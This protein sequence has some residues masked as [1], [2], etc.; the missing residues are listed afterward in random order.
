[1]AARSA[2]SR[3]GLG[4]ILVTRGLLSADQLRLSFEQQSVSGQR[5]GEIVVEQG[6]V[7]P[8]DLALALSEQHNLP[9]LDILDEAID[10]E[11]A[12]LL[13]EHL[14]QRYRALPVRV[15]DERT[16]LVAVSDPAD[17]QS[18][19]GLRLALKRKIELAVADERDLGVAQRRT[20]RSGGDLGEAQDAVSKGKDDREDIVVGA[21]GGV[22]A[23]KHVHSALEHCIAEGASDI[24]FE[25]EADRVVVRARVDGMMR[26][27]ATIPK[28]L[29]SE[30]TTRLKIMASLDI[31]E[32]RAPQDGRMFVKV[33]MDPVDLRVAV[34]PTTHG[35]QVVVRVLQRTARA[36][37]L[38]E[39]GMHPVAQAALVQA[40][41]QPH[42]AI[43]ACG[44]T[45]SGKTTTLYSALELL[46]DPTRALMTIEDPVEYAVP[47]VAQI[48][49]RPRSGLTFAQ[50]LRTLL[51][52]DPDVL[53]IGEIR[54]D[55]T[56]R[57]A[58][59]AAMTGHLVLTSLHTHGATSAIERL[60][61]MGVEPSLLSA[62]L[63][64]IV[65]Q[66]LAR[67]L[68]LECRQPYTPSA[69]DMEELEMEGELVPTL[70]EAT[71][72]ARCGR[73]GYRGRV[74][75]YE[76]LPVRERVRSLVRATT[77]EIAA[78]AK[79]EG[80]RTLKQEGHRLAVEGVTSLSEVRRVTG[81]QLS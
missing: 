23:V 26:E 45:G 55:E 77:D 58:I 67:R 74:A 20:Y 10:E 78:A 36:V 76:V 16:V 59:Q 39:L 18:L 3:R 71:G 21:A 29:Q 12:A 79:Q 52:S 37:G 31:A 27:M 22:P 34:L 61:D 5:L 51:R 48:E 24:H 28:R 32:R 4:A 9:F 57:I 35:E 65:A 41:S 63:N 43:V 11:V 80:M 33:G 62:S 70:Y 49:V 69:E 14:A 54:D 25:P 7:S 66:R 64:C 15:V 1:V 72:C 53:L 42:G 17:V 44:P 13:P 2:V 8:L 60:K 75:L 81:G 40:L 38:A 68:C 46:N 73:T 6:W 50:G 47:G 19:D 30:V 56:A